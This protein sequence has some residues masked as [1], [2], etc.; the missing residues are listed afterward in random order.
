[1]PSEYFPNLAKDRRH[2][3]TSYIVKMLEILTQFCKKKRSEHIH[4]PPTYAKEAL[5]FFAPY[6][7][8]LYSTFISN[9][10]SIFSLLENKVLVNFK[11]PH[12][13]SAGNVQLSS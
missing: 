12:C 13:I 11:A 1:M 4:F 2:F 8:N 9:A 3:S 7:S 10:L 6:P 5:I